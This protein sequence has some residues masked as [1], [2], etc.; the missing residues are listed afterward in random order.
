MVVMGYYFVQFD[1]FVIFGVGEVGLDK[2][3][4]LTDASR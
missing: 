2:F 1:D 4:L 3:Q